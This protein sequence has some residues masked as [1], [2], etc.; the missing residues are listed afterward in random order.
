M[1]DIGF[2]MKE[3]DLR[4]LKTLLLNI[5]FNDSPLSLL[6]ALDSLA[7]A[8]FTFALFV[9]TA[10]ALLASLVMSVSVMLLEWKH[11]ASL[12]NFHVNISL[13]LGATDSFVDLLN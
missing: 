11:A 10:V 4:F 13:L 6:S 8:T 5:Y 1:Y 7:T 2:K 3:L 12:S 9:I